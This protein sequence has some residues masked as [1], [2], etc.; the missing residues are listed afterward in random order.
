[1]P[2]LNILKSLYG[3]V[4]AKHPTLSLLGVSLLGAIICGGSWKLIGLWYYADLAATAKPPSSHAEVSGD[5]SSATSGNG[6]TTTI[7]C[8]K[9]KEPTK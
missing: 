9:P 8:D 3:I 1:M 2:N 7:T 6:N 4:G 5:C